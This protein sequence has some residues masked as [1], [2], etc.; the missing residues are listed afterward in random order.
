MSP[1]AE[2]LPPADVVAYVLADLAIIL[3]A[4]RL[5]GGLF[6][7]LGQPRVVGE[8]IAGILIGPTVLGG[9]LAAAPSPTAP[10]GIA[11]TGLVNEIYPLQA[12][13]FL[14]LIGQVTLVLYMFL[15]GLELDQRL[16]RGQGGPVTVMAVA[17]VGVPIGFGF[18]TGFYFDDPTWKPPGVATLPF[19]LLLGAGL[20]VT[21]FPVMARI[22]QEKDLMRTK[23]AAVGIGTA[24]VVTVLM[25]LAIAAAS[26]AAA[27]AGV[28]SGVAL[29][30]GLVLALAAFLLLAIRPLLR[31]WVDRWEPGKPLGN[32]LAVML[33]GALVTALAT[34]R[35]LGVALVGGFLF[36]V[37]VP[38][39][40]GLPEAVVER[41]EDAVVLFFLPVF[42]AV[43][44]LRTDL[45]TISL[46]LVP[47][48][49][50]FL[51]LMV[52][53]KWGAGYAAGRAVGLRS[54]MAHTVG[55]LLNCR[56]LLILVVGLIG[57]QLG[58]ITQ[59]MQAVF[60]I[61]AVVTT[62]MT[63]PLVDVFLRREEVE[64][65]A[66]RRSSGVAVIG[67]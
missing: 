67:A 54:N 53:G 58:L 6:V 38:A 2:F 36:G 48:L 21:A 5:V 33:V 29:R 65:K 8:I 10:Q 30:L 31:L 57:L 15:V 62:L 1:P 19:L 27:R 9:T 47:G 45:R 13:S 18:A 51:A 40:E 64:L 42:L 59:E 52:V 46:D 49:L 60:V 44:G 41:L 16:L 28:V 50:L 17:A 56:G 24:A 22:L 25:F 39:K 26:A 63:G 23:M 7:R 43:S 34:D 3:A 32:L 35:I 66:R 4:A 37:A 20:S 61:G 11:G 14:N 55:V 12:F